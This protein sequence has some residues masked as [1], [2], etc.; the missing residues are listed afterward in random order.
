M[1]E[2]TEELK[3]IILQ[4]KSEYENDNLK[5]K[6]YIEAMNNLIEVYMEEENWQEAYELLEKCIEVFPHEYK[7]L[8]TGIYRRVGVICTINFYYVSKKLQKDENIKKFEDLKQLINAAEHEDIEASKDKR[9]SDEAN[10]LNRIELY[11]KK[12]KSKENSS[13][14]QKELEKIFK[15]HYWSEHYSNHKF[16]WE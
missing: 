5:V 9:T 12:Y 8:S 16:S 11:K 14:L 3:L 2:S 1:C 10:I 7:V 13:S 15:T 6:D 4:K